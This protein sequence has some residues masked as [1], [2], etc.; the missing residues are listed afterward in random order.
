MKKL[1]NNHAE[2]RLSAFQLC[3]ELFRRAH[4][5]RVMLIK[6][7]EDVLELT[8]GINPEK[9]VPKPKDVAERLKKLVLLTVQQWKREYGATYKQFILCY[10]YLT[11]C[12]NINLDAVEDEVNLAEQER[13]RRENEIRLAKEKVLESVIEGYNG[14]TATKYVSGTL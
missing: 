13:L 8:A 2:V 1:R 4:A 7:L 11:Q 10:N 9:P 5:F 3:V 14:K 6:N 12:K